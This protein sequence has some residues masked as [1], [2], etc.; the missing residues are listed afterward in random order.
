MHLGLANKIN[1][2][3][4]MVK[5]TVTSQSGVLRFWVVAQQASRAPRRA[6]P[7][8]TSLGSITVQERT[9]VPVKHKAH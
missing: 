2:S 3:T 5:Q 6:P 8:G 4:S 1:I 7:Q 9:L